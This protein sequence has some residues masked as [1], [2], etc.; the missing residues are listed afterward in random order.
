MKEQHHY[1]PSAPMLSVPRSSERCTVTDRDRQQLHL[2]RGTNSQEGRGRE[3]G[4]FLPQFSVA[5]R[6]PSAPFLNRLPRLFIPLPP[7]PTR[8][9]GNPLN[10]SPSMMPGAEEEAASNRN[11]GKNS[12]A[13]GSIWDCQ[14]VALCLRFSGSFTQFLLLSAFPPFGFSFTVFLHSNPP[15]KICS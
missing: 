4:V 2:P 14:S 3:A 1:G 12:E 6:T 11:R 7:N 10:S 15:I 8:L 13:P 5:L 9:L